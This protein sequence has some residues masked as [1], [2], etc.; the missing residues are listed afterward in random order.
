MAMANVTVKQFAEVLGVPVERLLA[1][2]VEAGLAELV[3]L[4]PL[5]F[6]KQHRS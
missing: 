4:E 3:K 2:L 6:L 1:Q 5:D